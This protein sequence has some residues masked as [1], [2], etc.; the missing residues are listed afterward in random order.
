MP[1]PVVAAG[2]AVVQIRV[3]SG[4][5]LQIVRMNGQD[6]ALM[7]RRVG[8]G[9]VMAFKLVDEKDIPLLELIDAVVYKKLFSSGNREVDFITVVD[10]NAHGLLIVIQSGNCKGFCIQA[11]LNG[12]FTGIINE[13]NVCAAPYL[14]IVNVF[15]LEKLQWLVYSVT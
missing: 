15:L 8:F 9:Q 1:K 10:V 14:R 4:K 5:M 11:C 6:N 7:C 2:K 13:H 12:R 3:G